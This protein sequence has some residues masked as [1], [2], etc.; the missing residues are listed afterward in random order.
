MVKELIAE[1]K[2]RRKDKLQKRKTNLN[3]DNSVA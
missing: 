2:A 3:F 1:I